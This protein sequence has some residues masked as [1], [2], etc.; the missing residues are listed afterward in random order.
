MLAQLEKDEKRDANARASRVF[1]ER[2]AR[3]KDKVI[4]MREQE[5]CVV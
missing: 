4:R 3:N 1:E 2:Y 5:R